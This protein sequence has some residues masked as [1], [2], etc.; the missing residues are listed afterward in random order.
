MS[1]LI[2]LMRLTYLITENESTKSIHST[3]KTAKKVVAIEK[4]AEENNNID[5]CRRWMCC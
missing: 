1:Q 2:Q 4:D 5:D 3:G